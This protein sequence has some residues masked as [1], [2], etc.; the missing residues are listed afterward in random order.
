MVY[1]VAPFPL[2][3]C[4]LGGLGASGDFAP[5][6][7]VFRLSDSDFGITIDT[8]VRQNKLKLCWSCHNKPCS[9][10]VKILPRPGFAFPKQ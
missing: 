6:L 4:L 8:V 1:E 7:S 5:K 10:A 9:A 2:P 3:I